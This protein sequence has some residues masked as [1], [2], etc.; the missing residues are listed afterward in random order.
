MKAKNYD[1]GS[2][3]FSYFRH[4]GLGKVGGLSQRVKQRLCIW[5]WLE[6]AF[7]WSRVG[8]LSNF[9]C[10]KPRKHSSL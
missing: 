5:A 6:K 3:K 2:V 10:K 4:W 9:K 8:Q 1:M 7:G